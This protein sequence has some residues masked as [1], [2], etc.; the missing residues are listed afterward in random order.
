MS[1]STNNKILSSTVISS[2]DVVIDNKA[3]LTFPI[4]NH[5]Q[6]IKEQIEQ[7][8]DTLLHI[9][10]VA[11]AELLKT[12]NYLSSLT[13]NKVALYFS[14]ENTKAAI[15]K[16]AV[17]LCL[18]NNANGWHQ[19][20]AAVKQ[21]ENKL[22]NLKTQYEQIKQSVTTIESLLK[23]PAANMVSHHQKIKENL[24]E[25][26]ALELILQPALT[27]LHFTVLAANAIDPTVIKQVFDS[28][29]Q[30]PEYIVLNKDNYVNTV[31]LFIK[32]SEIVQN[33][34]PQLG[35]LNETLNQKAA[36]FHKMKAEFK[37]FTDTLPTYPNE[38][39]LGKTTEMCDKLQLAIKEHDQLKAHMKS[40]E[41]QKVQAEKYLKYYQNWS[42][43]AQEEIDAAKLIE[44][45]K[46][47]NID[48]GKQMELDIE[49]NTQIEPHVQKLAHTETLMKEQQKIVLDN[50]ILLKNH[51]E[52]T[53][54][55]QSETAQK[56]LASAAISETDVISSVP[57]VMPV[58][59]PA[60]S[61]VVFHTETTSNWG[62]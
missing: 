27:K 47:E 7:Q 4:L 59:M 6:E 34:L 41:E 10:P 25:I 2:A 54:Y 61:P 31:K 36:A 51:Q 48:L 9:N 23:N 43:V 26:K 45:K 57:D 17:E 38:E 55:L 58:A 5:V 33:G 21:A 30:S 11:H 53:D 16:Q 56:L 14:P 39:Q 50:Q 15:H 18:K 32:A 22:I 1:E 12:V 24:A 60:P 35:K 52:A 19:A 20:E 37:A 40:L 8:K 49:L 29:Q 28:K 46:Q 44:I 42:E 3:S 62:D 13:I